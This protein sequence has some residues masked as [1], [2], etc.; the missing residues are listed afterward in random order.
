MK[1]KQSDQREIGNINLI[2]LHI[3]PKIGCPFFV[4]PFC[5]CAILVA[6]QM[7]ATSHAKSL[8]SIATHQTVSATAFIALELQSNL[9][10]CSAHSVHFMEGDLF[11]DFICLSNILKFTK[12]EWVDWA[13]A[14]M[15]MLKQRAMDG[16]VSAAFCWT[17]SVGGARGTS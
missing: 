11:F 16:G 12:L 6:S 8:A 9:P 1:F 5:C 10:N 4:V 3:I 15:A 13:H 2:C 14:F 7:S 17:N